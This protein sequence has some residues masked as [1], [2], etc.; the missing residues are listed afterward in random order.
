MSA[1][2]WCCR[3]RRLMTSPC[4]SASAAFARICVHGHR[5]QALDVGVSVRD[6]IIEGR[7]RV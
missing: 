7:D 2:F 5:G 1:Q 3:M 6:E 4:A